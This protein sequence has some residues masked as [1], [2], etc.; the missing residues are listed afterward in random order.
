MVST[1]NW[2]GLNPVPKPRDPNRRV[3]Q[4]GLPQPSRSTNGQ[5]TKPATAQRGKRRTDAADPDAI[6]LTTVHRT[7]IAADIE[8]FGRHS[9]NNTNQVRI[10]HGMYRAMQQAFE[11]VG[12]PWH[13]CRRE[14]RGDG[15]LVLASAEVSKALFVDDLPIVLVDE[16]TR[17][18]KSHPPAE[19][20]R[21]KLALH[22]GEVNYD[23]HGVTGS[24]ITHTFRLVDADVL[25]SALTES[26][27]VLAIISSAWF[28]EEVVR[29]SEGSCSR[30]Y[31]Q[32]EVANKETTARAWIRLV[33]SPRRV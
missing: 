8:G 32:A 16:L 33:R 11:A 1:A 15:V 31:R 19:R 25:K 18:N 10:R 6:T 20:I 5:S 29:H 30:S 17:H 23:Q 2:K 4:K 26:S 21:L 22:A 27:A 13:S 14:D 7:I 28:F 3:H 12:I 9:R 24:S